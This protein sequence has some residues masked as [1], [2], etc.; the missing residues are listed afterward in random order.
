MSST[1]LLT[2]NLSAMA[3]N[4]LVLKRHAL[5]AE[6]AAVVK[7]DAY[8]LGVEQVALSL[9]LAGC[10]TFFVSTLDEAVE[11][12]RYMSIEHRIIVLGG[13]SHDMTPS[14][15][16]SIWSDKHL[17]PVLFDF[18]HLERWSLHAKGKDLPSVIKVDTGMHRFG[19]SLSEMT[20]VLDSSKYV[21]TCQPLMLMS[22][23]ACA[24][25]PE[26][27]LNHRQFVLF[28]QLLAKI[29]EINPRV[30]G[31]LANS[32][33]IFLDDHECFDMVRPGSAI[34]GVNPTPGHVNPVSEVIQLQLP[35]MQFK[36]LRRG[37]Y[38]GYGADF[39]APSDMR[40]AVVF[41]GYADGVLRALS[42]SG[43]AYYGGCKVPLLGRVSMDSMVFDISSVDVPLLSPMPFLELV[44]KH[45]SIDQL[46]AMAGTIGYELL[47]S[48][49]RR[50]QR[51]YTHMD[52]VC[53][54]EDSA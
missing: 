4:W 54:H 19:L 18:G 9:S 29:R 7:A 31:S 52:S 13:L 49:G 26:H 15:C 16:S 35:I 46:A 48:L 50:Y 44:G 17:I 51:H 27:P 40:V 36:E 32:S 23:L 22:H 6:C 28:Q 34:Y 3:S 5:G 41:G 2:V 11:L 45:Q 14:G 8:G 1:G 10:R 39:Q 20:Q 12:R 42:H 47:T 25:T 24:D 53:S 43:F 37:D 30:L 21:N 33:G 38:V